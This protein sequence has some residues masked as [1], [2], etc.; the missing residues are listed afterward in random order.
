MADLSDV[1]M[2]HFHMNMTVPGGDGGGTLAHCLTFGV[3]QGHGDFRPSATNN[4]FNH[5]LGPCCGCMSKH[6]HIPVNTLCTLYM[7]RW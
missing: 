5:L 3:H 7:F 4:V 1:E 6:M 2:T